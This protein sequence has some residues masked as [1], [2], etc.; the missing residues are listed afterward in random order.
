M[1]GWYPIFFENHDQP[2]SVNKFFPEGAD[3]EL[4]AKA[5]E[6]AGTTTD[7]TKLRDALAKVQ[8][9]ESAVGSMTFNGSGDPEVDLVLL[10]V[11]NG[12]YTALNVAIRYQRGVFG[13]AI[14]NINCSHNI[15]HR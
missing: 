14:T 15:T 13:V 7:S 10:K 8:N 2:R 5:M 12:K 4:A 6:D 11:E 3:P 1:D 9:F